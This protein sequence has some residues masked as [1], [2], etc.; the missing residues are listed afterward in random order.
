M[1][2]VPFLAHVDECRICRADRQNPCRAG[3]ELLKD[4]AQRLTARLVHDPK[5][6]KA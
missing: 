2:M 5:R 3:A 6:A 1:S 4:G